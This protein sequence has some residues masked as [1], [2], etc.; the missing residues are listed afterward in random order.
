MVWLSGHCGLHMFKGKLY[1]YV[2]SITAAETCSWESYIGLFIRSLRVGVHGKL[3]SVCLSDHCGLEVLSGDIGLLIRL[4]RLE[5][6]Q[7]KVIS[8]VYPIL[9]QGWR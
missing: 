7:R 2:Y 3:I 6:I 4:L 9:P 5:D 8:F 1:R